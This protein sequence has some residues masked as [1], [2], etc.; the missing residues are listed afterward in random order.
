M[1]LARL[2][3]D[4]APLLWQIR[5]DGFHKVSPIVEVPEVL[6]VASVP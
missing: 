5:V 1:S 4:A 3:K 6:A 2:T